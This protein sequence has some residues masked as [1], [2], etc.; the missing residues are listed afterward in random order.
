[1]KK[2]INGKKYDTDTAKV[3]HNHEYFDDTVCK[4]NTRMLFQKVNGEYFIYEDGYT[5][6]GSI[7]AYQ[8]IRPISLEEAKK[9]LENL[10]SVEEYETHFGY[11]EE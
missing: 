4:W 9:Y 8:K 6:F 2:I 1:M 10:V 3:I 5:D 11:V 7:R